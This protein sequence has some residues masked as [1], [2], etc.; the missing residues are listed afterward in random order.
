MC[1]VMTGD[2]IDALDPDLVERVAAAAR[3]RGETVD[4]VIVRAL[5]RYLR[6]SPGD[7]S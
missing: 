5:T 3:E 4:D 2:G 6:R 1:G 7:V